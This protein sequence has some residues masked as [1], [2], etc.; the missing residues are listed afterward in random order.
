MDSLIGQTNINTE[1]IG[2]DAKVQVFNRQGNEVPIDGDT[3][4]MTRNPDNIAIIIA[5]SADPARI[6]IAGLKSRLTLRSAFIP[7]RDLS[8]PKVKARPIKPSDGLI[9][10]NNGAISESIAL[11]PGISDM[12]SAP[13]NHGVTLGGAPTHVVATR[14]D[15][16]YVSGAGLTPPTDG[17]MPV[18]IVTPTGDQHGADL[19]AW[20]YVLGAAPSTHVNTW[21]PIGFQCIGLAP[22]TQIR[23]SF[24]PT[25]SQTIEP[26]EIKMTCGSADAL[27][28][29]AQY[30]TSQ[31][32]P[33]ILNATVEI[34]NL[35]D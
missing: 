17:S 21:A 27:T 12:A 29:V 7:P 13:G 34:K 24:R 6:E 20:G 23:I 3:V 31:L 4:I 28:A 18:N 26:T 10:V 22:D 9:D 8:L 16:I 30:K 19:P 35:D 5:E 14:A 33:Q 11:P 1:T 2:D 32:G 25:G 15:E